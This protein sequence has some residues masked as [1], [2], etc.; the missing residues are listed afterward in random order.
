MRI[1]KAVKGHG[2]RQESGSGRKLRPREK[3]GEEAGC[4]LRTSGDFGTTKSCGLGV[5]IHGKTHIFCGI[6]TKGKT[7]WLRARPRP[8]NTAPILSRF[9]KGLEAVRKRPGMYIG[10]TDDGSG[11]HHMVYEVVDNG[12]DEALGGSRRPCDNVTVHADSSVSVS[13]N[14]RGDSGGYPRG[15]GRFGGRGHHDPAS[16]GR[17]VRPEFLQGVG[18][19]ARRGRF[20][21]ERAVRLAGA[22]DLAGRQRACCAIRKVA[23]RRTI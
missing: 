14:G 6:I 5:T 23:R 8:K 12:I 10:D 22:A 16:R 21:G 1:F 2:A 11:L 3:G 17:E 19:S 13:D 4:S 9:S 20:G 7:A 15:R 18:R